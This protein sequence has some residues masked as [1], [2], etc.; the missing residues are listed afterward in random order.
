MRSQLLPFA[1][2]CL[3]ACA[4]GQEST[5][6]VKVHL[7]QPR[8]P[9]EMDRFALGQGGQSEEP[10]FASRI[11]EVR[12]L[13]PRLIRLFVQE[14]F[15]VLPERGRYDW[16]TL[17]DS[18][19]AIVKTGASPLM[20]IAIK[21]GVLYPKIDQDIVDPVSYEEWDNLIFEMVRHYKERGSGI[22]YWEVSNEP[23]IGEDGGSP[24]R[25]KPDNYPR[26]YDHTVRAI[27]RA[28]PEARVGGPAL[29][30]SRSALLPALLEF[31]NREKTPLDFV[32]WHIYSSDPLQVRGTI[33]RTKALI[34]KYPSLKVETFLD[35]WNMSLSNPALDPRFQ[36]CYIAEVA[37]QMKEG[38]L[39][40]SCYYHIRDYHV[41]P[42]TFAR[43]TSPAGVALMDKWWN[44]MSQFDGLFD[45]QNHVRPAYYTFRLLA[46]LTGQ[47]LALESPEGTVHG[48]ASYDGGLQRYNVMLWNYSKSAAKV[49]LELDG[50]PA[51]LSGKRLVLDAMNPI[52]DEN[53]RLRPEGSFP[54]KPGMNQ[55]DVTL[56]P[57]GVTFLFFDRNR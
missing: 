46:R 31:C 37:W 55:L 1:V 52:Q 11:P 51:S 40:Y 49:N 16:K 23:D 14:Y 53:T 54:L 57:W 36:P 24:Y 18:V 32:S 7:D 33:D 44:Q 41:R 13:R 20:C 26:Y 35:E 45:F 19:D 10:I 43:Y 27:R 4:A 9:M 25:F 56:E 21:P 6:T 38:G 48:F 22:R 42:E 28:D 29:A 39:D 5:V 47:R 2:L 15:H 3:A 34:A 30:N 8:G 17:D 50:A 12:A